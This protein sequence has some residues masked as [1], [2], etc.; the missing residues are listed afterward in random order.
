MIVQISLV[1]VFVGPTGKRGN[2]K[3]VHFSGFYIFLYF[4]T[5]GLSLFNLHC[6]KGESLE[7]IE[8]LK[9][10]IHGKKEDGRGETVKKGGMSS[11]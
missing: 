5:F 8:V 2:V 11:W 7:V 1:L 9:Y 3:N 6:N 10:G 4:R